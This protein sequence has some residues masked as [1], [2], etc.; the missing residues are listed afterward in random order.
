MTNAKK[1]GTIVII[2]IVVHVQCCIKVLC[3]S[4]STPPNELAQAFRNGGSVE[5]LLVQVQPSTLETALDEVQL[6]RIHVHMFLQNALALH[7]IAAKL[8]GRL[9]QRN[10][11][12][13]VDG[14]NLIVLQFLEVSLA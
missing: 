14:S 5:F 3:S 7:H 4:S 12:R 2:L 9:L 11:N 8:S 13:V 6:R 10:R 1:S